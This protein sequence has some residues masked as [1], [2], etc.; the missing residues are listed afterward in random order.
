MTVGFIYCAFALCIFAQN[1]MVCIMPKVY[2]KRLPA[3]SKTEQIMCTYFLI[4]LPGTL[5]ATSVV[6]VFS[7]IGDAL[8]HLNAKIT[9]KSL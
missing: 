5:L 7:V 8:A 6:N 1:T 4:V 2:C 3:F 9:Q